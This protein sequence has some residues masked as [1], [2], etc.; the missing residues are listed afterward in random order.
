M[1]VAFRVAF[2]PAH[3]S[4][5]ALLLGRAAVPP[6]SGTRAPRWVH[7]PRPQLL[8][9]CPWLESPR[10]T[11]FVPDPDEPGLTC[12]APVHGACS[13]LHLISGWFVTKAAL[14]PQRDPRPPP[15]PSSLQGIIPGAPGAARP[16]PQEHRSRPISIHPPPGG[17]HLHGAGGCWG[18]LGLPGCRLTPGLFA[19][20]ADW[21]PPPSPHWAG[22]PGRGLGP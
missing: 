2:L 20:R 6:S 18:V 1:A 14:R 12:Q 17:S 10:T 4:R 5:A 11:S 9:P 22:G 13:S 21:G 16:P 15:C 19:C 8:E 3:P 7:K